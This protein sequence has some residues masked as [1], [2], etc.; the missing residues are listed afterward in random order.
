M[1]DTHLPYVQ[2]RQAP[3]EGQARNATLPDA[4]TTTMVTD[5]SSGH[6]TRIEV[7]VASDI[8]VTPSLVIYG[9]SGDIAAVA[10]LSATVGGTDYSAVH[11]GACGQYY[12]LRL[13]NAS[14]GVGNVTVWTAAK[15]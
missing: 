15:A 13:A 12:D 2:V 3:A 6:A 10:T 8:V 1:A 14:G 4:T 9:A 5:V 7:L 11:T